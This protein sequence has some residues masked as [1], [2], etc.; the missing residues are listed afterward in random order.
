[1]A[2]DI[3][4][5]T[6]DQTCFQA[7]MFRAVKVAIVATRPNG[8]IVYWNPFAEQLYGWQVQEVIGRS[9]IEIMVPGENQ[10]SAEDIMG[11]VRA[12]ESWTGEFTLKRRDGTHLT[13]SVT[14]S[15]IF[16]ESGHLIGIVGV[17]H[18]LT[19][20]AKARLELQRQV[21]ERTEELRAAN[22]SLRQLSA[23]LVQSQD[24]ERR[25][26]ARELHDTTGQDLT[27]LKIDLA[28]IGREANKFSPELARRVSDT[29]ALVT[30]ISDD[31]RTMSYLLH[32]PLLDELGVAS[33]LRHYVEGF[34]ARSHIK[35][36]L[37]IQ[38]DFGR[39]ADDME[40]TCFR[41]VQEC[42]TNI[43]RHSKSAKAVI[44]MNYEN[45]H[46]LVEVRDEGRGIPRERVSELT[47]G[48]SGVGLA[49]M[50]ERVTQLGG[51]LEIKSDATGTAIIAILPLKHSITGA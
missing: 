50:R 11:S 32:P 44:T 31:L 38:P 40:I 47:S 14:D 5:R 49:G 42:L 19:A 36:D 27:V 4:Q 10:Q 13:A 7:R 25:R 35:V 12:G 18:D 39:L 23:N 24:E 30:H 2:T 34:S 26:F 41:I 45:E 43:H 16:D 8:Q 37:K 17:S 6:E 15:P 20:V 48:G 33:A 1:M 21:Q 3:S 29:N 51:T 22:E 46:I 28:F 9:I